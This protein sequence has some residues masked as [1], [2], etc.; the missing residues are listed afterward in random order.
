M[1][2]L[3]Q[4]TGVLIVGAGPSG[5]M[6]AAQLLRY[7]VQPVI[8]DLKKGPTN[9]S[10]ALAVQAR[11]LEIYRQMGLVDKVLEGGKQAGG[12]A[13]YTEGEQ[14]ATIS[15]KDVGKTDTLYPFIHL[16]Q[17]S[18]NE[19]AL[20][21]YLT[22]ACC[23]VYWETTLISLKQNKDNAEVILQSGN[24]NHTLLCNYV[25]GADGAHSAVRK[26]LDIPFTGDTYQHQF[27]LADV[28]ITNK[29]PG[30]IVSLFLAK[31]GFAGFF[32]MPEEHSYRIVG[33]LPDKLANKAD[34]NIND[35]LPALK[36][37]TTADVEIAETR[38]FTLYKLHHRMAGRFSDGRCFLIG[39]AAH[40]HS[41]V[42]G[43]GMN[44]GLQ[45]AYNLAWKLAAVV[46]GQIK[47]SILSSYAD[48]RMPVAKELLNTT[49]RIFNIITSRGWFS[50]LLKR[51]VIPNVLKLLWK[52]HQLR[53]YFFR[54]VSQTGISYRDSKINLQLSRD[55]KIK[56]G[57]RLPYLEIFDEKKKAKTDIH[58]WCSK[59]GF[60]LIT[61]GEIKEA[62]L[63]T[64]AKW[65]TQDYRGGLNFFH[66]P[67]SNTN[68]HVFDAFEVKP[69]MRRALIIRPDLHIGYMNDVVDIEMMNNYLKNV[70][71]FAG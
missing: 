52:N 1:I 25:I 13:L 50:G 31:S 57:D 37:I 59:P 49:D 36:G 48:E 6:M 70:V 58:T 46:K 5:L 28:E 18:K 51:Y 30:D 47:Q 69:G 32:P 68:W 60:T 56:A 11:S 8:I 34:L 9:Q 26:Q 3:P 17:Q 55:T 29:T 43:Q 40:I 35:I 62:Y 39:D 21:D 22:T 38:W 2:A 16:Y 33:S 27:Y 23:P 14:A 7:G 24:T 66:L 41:P 45:D 42:G 61:L 53:E 63:F 4:H 65:I 54:R 10:K 44:T 67:P 71:G 19:R 12:L 20:L 15:L 64:L